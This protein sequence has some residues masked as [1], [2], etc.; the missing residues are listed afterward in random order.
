MITVKCT[1]A[2]GDTITTRFNGTFQE[3]EAYFLN[4]VFNVGTVY[5]DMQ[6]CIKVEEYC[7]G[8]TGCKCSGCRELLRKMD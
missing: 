4:R 1:Y 7:E 6:K 8:H 2:K 5:D 3:A